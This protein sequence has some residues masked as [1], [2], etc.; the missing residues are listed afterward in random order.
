M[1]NS[2]DPRTSALLI[3]HWQNELVKPGG[4]VA[5]AFSGVLA[6]FG[7]LSGCRM[8]FRRA[9][10]GVM[11]VYV[12]ASHRK[13]YPELPANP[14]PL[15]AGLV[16]TNA[17]IRGTWGAEVIDELRPLEDEIR[18]PTTRQARS[19]QRARPHSSKPR[20]HDRRTCRVG[21]QLGRR[22]HRSGRLQQG[23]FRLDLGRL[24]Q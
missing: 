8:R 24:L 12:N 1:Q 20:D 16:K 21:H 2:I 13:G 4:L 14:A 15:A 11:V 3:L 23:L 6:E 18:S 9:G 10:K 17:F 19:L 5:A 7:T 22:E